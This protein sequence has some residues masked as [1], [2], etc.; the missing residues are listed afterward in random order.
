MSIY[1]LEEYKRLKQIQEMFDAVP[2]EYIPTEDELKFLDERNRLEVDPD[3]WSLEGIVAN[4]GKLLEYGLVDKMLKNLDFL[5]VW[6]FV[7]G[8][9]NFMKSE[10]YRLF[11]DHKVVKLAY[12]EAIRRRNF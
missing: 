12:L 4:Y 3:V 6:R 5:I 9:E 2:D 10:F 1:K 11:K 8:K 7:D